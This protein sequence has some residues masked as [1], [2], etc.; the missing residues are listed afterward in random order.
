MKT[1]EEIKAMRDALAEAHA[2]KVMDEGDW[3]SVEAGQSFIL[4]FDKALEL[5]EERER[6]Q[7]KAL[8][9][10]INTINKLNEGAAKAWRV[11]GIGGQDQWAG[12]PPA[13]KLIEL[14]LDEIQNLTKG[15]NK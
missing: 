1:L 3:H 11:G 14:S 8:E 13:R 6:A 2:S 4:G 5:M 10:A 7:K 12:I 9:I 15:E